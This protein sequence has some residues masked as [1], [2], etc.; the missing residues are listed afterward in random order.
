MQKYKGMVFIY[1]AGN[2]IDN[3]NEADEDN[4]EITGV[5]ITGVTETTA[6]TEVMTQPEIENVP[7]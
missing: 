5:E 4:S 7:Q 3:S 6:I 2:I 1:Q